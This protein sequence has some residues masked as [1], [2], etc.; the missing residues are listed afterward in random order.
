MLDYLII[1]L[2]LFSTIKF[3]YRF[4][5]DRKFLDLESVKKDNAISASEIHVNLKNLKWL[6]RYDNPENELKVLKQALKIVNKDDRNLTL[7]THYNF[8]STVLII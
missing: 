3:H 7:I 8:M 6:S 2:V 1:L 4:N 5:I